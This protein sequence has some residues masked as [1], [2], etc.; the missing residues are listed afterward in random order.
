MA[1][2]GSNYGA[3]TV[4]LAAPGSG[5]YSTIPNSYDSFSG[6]SMATPFVAGVASLIMTQNPSLSHLEVKQILL[7]TT[8]YLEDFKGKSVT[9][10]RLNAYNALNSSIELAIK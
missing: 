9:E 8:D 7:T 10:G 4:D 5:I 1:T 3:I 6:T 2:P